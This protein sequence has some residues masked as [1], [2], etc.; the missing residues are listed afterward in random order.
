MNATVTTKKS[1]VTNVYMLLDLAL[2]AVLST[3]DVFLT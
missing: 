1:C 2:S 3:K